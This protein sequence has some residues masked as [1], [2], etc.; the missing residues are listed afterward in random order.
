MKNVILIYCCGL[1]LLSCGGEDSSS[2][3]EF[4]DFEKVECS[5]NSSNKAY[6]YYTKIPTE[7]YENITQTVI[8]LLEWYNIQPEKVKLS[9]KFE[10]YINAKEKEHFISSFLNVFNPP[11]V[12][13]KE[14]SQLIFADKITTGQQLIEHINAEWKTNNP[15]NLELDTNQ[16]V[17]S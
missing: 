9:Q 15:T 11:L 6:S 13:Q 2:E 1:I 3:A 8:V 12:K 4:I 16:F 10:Y 7:P 14:F 5:S 17:T